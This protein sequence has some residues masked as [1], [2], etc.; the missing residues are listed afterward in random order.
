MPMLVLPS[1]VACC[2]PLGLPALSGFVAE[3][4]V[5]T[6][7]F[8]ILPVVTILSAF[9]VVLTAG[10]LLWML[11]RDFYGPLDL[12]WSWLTDAAPPE[13]FP[14]SALPIAIILGGLHPHPLIDPLSPSLHPTRAPSY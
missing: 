6:G 5:F 1:S 12:R 14:L 4:L 8:A 13:A 7:T 2:A 11:R 10:F 3:Y 9:G